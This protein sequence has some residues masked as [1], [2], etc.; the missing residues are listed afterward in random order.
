MM[1]P[2]KSLLALSIAAI[3]LAQS[4]YDFV[5]KGGRVI[6]GKN[7]LSAIRDVAVKDG[8]IAAVAPDIDASRALKAVDVS[9]LYVTP[10]LIDMH[11]H[12]FPGPVKNSYAN[13]D[14]GL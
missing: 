4:D 1:T 5:L 9:G 11:V 12:V 3:A 13:G 6:D 14:W 8:K 10:G 7:K 2:T